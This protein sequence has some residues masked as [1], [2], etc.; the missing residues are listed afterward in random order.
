M[1]RYAS[2][3]F[4]PAGLIG[5]GFSMRPFCLTKFHEPV[6]SIQMNDHVKALEQARNKLINRRR[7]LAP[8]SRRYRTSAPWRLTATNPA[9]ASAAGS[10][11]MPFAIFL[12]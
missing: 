7:S 8:W 6:W 2:D 11:A 12:A 9:A 10:L 5:R 3:G 1:G 4:A